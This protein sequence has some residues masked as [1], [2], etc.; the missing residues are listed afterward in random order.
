MR[1]PVCT[2]GWS[3]TTLNVSR[4]PAVSTGQP[5]DACLN[6]GRAARIT[7]CRTVPE[8]MLKCWAVTV[9]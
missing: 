5:E 4:S 3:E 8:I 7:A 9:G 2:R 6:L 1:I